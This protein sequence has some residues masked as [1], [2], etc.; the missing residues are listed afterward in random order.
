VVA[1][2]VVVDIPVILDEIN[3]VRKLCKIFISNRA[4]VV[5]PYHKKT[6]EIE[7]SRRCKSIGTTKRGI[8]PCYGDKVTRYGIRIEDLLNKSILI[9]KID[10]VVKAN[11]N[12]KSLTNEYY[13]YGKKLKFYITDT[14]KYLHDELKKGK[15]I[16]LEGAQGTLLDID[17][18][19]YPFTTSS[20]TTIGGAITGTGLPAN[21]IKKVIGVTK[22][23][24]TRVGAGPMT[25]EIFDEQCEHI[26]KVGKEFGT[27]TGRARRC[28]WLDLVGLNYA[29]MINGF[30]SLAITKLDVLAYLDEIKVCTKY[31]NGKPIYEK[32][33]SWSSLEL[34]KIK[35]YNYNELPK[36]M[37]LYLRFIERKLKVPI[38][39][40]SIGESREKTIYVPE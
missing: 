18:G 35:K 3:M 32:F 36:N 8:G 13:N 26:R 2:G 33:K 14:T 40:I 39:I 22:C 4:H 6:D 25:T 7:E 30:T 37:K 20:N 1:N 10:A 34:M 31:D 5:M 28:G 21:S 38:K 19:T 29:N 15:K 27:T 11:Y 12:K 16:L 9:E 17:H 23:Y 24:V